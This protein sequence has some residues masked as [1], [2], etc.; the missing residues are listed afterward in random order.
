M[1]NSQSWYPH[2]NAAGRWCAAN[3]DGEHIACADHAAALAEC[4]KRNRDEDAD[5]ALADL[6]QN[7]D[8]T[9]GDPSHDLR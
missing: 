3:R 8:P 5:M 4:D 9:A 6:S 7:T 2:R 1:L